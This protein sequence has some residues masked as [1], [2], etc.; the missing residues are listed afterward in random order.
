MEEELA[1]L[2]DK[3]KLL[4]KRAIE[5]L[6]KGISDAE[7][8]IKDCKTK[9]SPFDIPS[10]SSRAITEEILGSIKKSRMVHVIKH[11]PNSVGIT[12]VVE[13]DGDDLLIA[14]SSE[15]LDSLGLKTGD[16]VNIEMTDSGFLWH[17][18]FKVVNSEE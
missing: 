2:T 17:L 12:T 11:N 18:H 3:A 15:I 1:T 13:K 8:S 4:T 16:V 7:S 14:L 6:D 5:S 10:I 9:K